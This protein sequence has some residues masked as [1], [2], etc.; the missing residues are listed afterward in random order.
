MRAIILT[1]CC[2]ALAVACSSDDSSADTSEDPAEHACEHVATTGTSLSA[3][4]TRDDAPTLMLSE[5]PY[6]VTLTPSTRVFVKLEAPAT[7]LLFAGTAN[8][9]TGLFLDPADSDL[10]PESA[11]NEFCAEA[12]SEHW[13]L[14]LGSG[15]YTLSLGPAAVAEVWL[16]YVSAAGHGH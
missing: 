14:Q 11:P 8:V 9:V 2:S 3:S 1:I 10:L 7:A 16:A 13:D 15:A 6:T 4:A 5:E 12:I